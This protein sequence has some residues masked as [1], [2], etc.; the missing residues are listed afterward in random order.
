M[1]SVLISLTIIW[2]LN[3][4][5][6]MLGSKVTLSKALLCSRLLLLT[7]I[8]TFM[9][10]DVR[11][12]YRLRNI[13]LG[14]MRR[15]LWRSVRLLE[16]RCFTPDAGLDKTVKTFGHKCKS[17]HFLFS[18]F[19][20]PFSQFYGPWTF[21][22]SSSVLPLLSSCFCS[23]FYSCLCFPRSNSPY[24]FILTVR[25]LNIYN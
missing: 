8:Q 18:F 23:F 2:I 5:F 22:I 21:T 14:W 7:L 4:Q 9:E 25:D 13:Y 3:L 24:V 20:P 1:S 11:V 16:W 10:I 17:Q 12:K 19:S 15:M 6:Q